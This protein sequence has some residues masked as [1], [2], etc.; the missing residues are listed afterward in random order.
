MMLLMM[1]DIA[2]KQPRD[3]GQDTNLSA[4]HTTPMIEAVAP[5]CPATYQS[6]LPNCKAIAKPSG[7]RMLQVYILGF[8]LGFYAYETRTLGPGGSPPAPGARTKSFRASGRDEQF[9]ASGDKQPL[10]G[11]DSVLNCDGPM[12]R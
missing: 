7:Y 11:H 3:N 5:L 4:D 8:S 1:M 12:V 2:C 6:H 9:D 10:S